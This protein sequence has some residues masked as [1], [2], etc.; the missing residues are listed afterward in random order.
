M[1]K[2]SSYQQTR[3]GNFI[4]PVSMEGSIF[5]FSLMLSWLC[6]AQLFQSYPTLCDPMK[7]SPPGSSVHAILQARILEWVA[8][9]F[10]RGS[11]QPRGV[12]I[13]SDFPPPLCSLLYQLHC[14][15]PE[16]FYQAIWCLSVPKNFPPKHLLKFSLKLMKKGDLFPGSPLYCHIKIN[17]LS[18]T[19]GVYFILHTFFP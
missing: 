10:S 7:Y 8:I 3:F 17:F 5:K 4:D 16:L 2:A 1:V 6:C 12:A 13:I 9:S 19:Y 15:H 18:F 14:P 11:S